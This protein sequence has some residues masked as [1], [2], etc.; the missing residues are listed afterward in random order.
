MADGV[1][2]PFKFSK[3]LHGAVDDDFRRQV[4]Y[5]PGGQAIGP[6]AES[7]LRAAPCPFT[8]RR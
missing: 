7:H 5:I 6:T 8:R 3:E 1:K 4:R 2:K